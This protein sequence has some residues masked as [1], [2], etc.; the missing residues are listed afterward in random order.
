MLRLSALAALLLTAAASGAQPQVPL[1]TPY[2]IEGTASYDAAI[3]TPEAVLGYR[4]GE[5]HTRPE[6]VIRY[7]EAVAAA[8]PRVAAGYHGSTYEGRRL[9]HATVTSPANHARLETIRDA[10]LMLSESPEA[11]SD[12]ELGAMPVVVYQGYSV[13]GNEASGTEAALVYLY[14]LAAAQGPEIDAQ[15]AQAVILLDPMLNPDG[16]DRFADWVNGYRG[17]AAVADP[18]DRE[19][20]EVWPG[21]RTNHYFFDL[22][23]DWLPT[24]LKESQGRMAWWH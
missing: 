14:H 15:L 10:N 11:V 13:H 3:P 8:S 17:T 6:E 2:A 7:V 16:R 20:R 19:H 18:Q 22:N 12:G 4:I 9:V 1:A 23:R 21:G 5:R 24:E